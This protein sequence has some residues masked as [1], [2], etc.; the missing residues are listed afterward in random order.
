MQKQE[1]TRSDEEP[2]INEVAWHRALRIVTWVGT[3]LDR[4]LSWD[5]H[6]SRRGGIIHTLFFEDEKS[7]PKKQICKNDLPAGFNDP[8]EH[9]SH[10]PG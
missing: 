8:A 2:H 6:A 5:G 4:F 10:P 9:R 1:V 7:K 3:K